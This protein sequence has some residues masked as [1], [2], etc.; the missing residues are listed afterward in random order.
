M[1]DPLDVHQLLSSSEIRNLAVFE[2]GRGEEFQ[3]GKS[4]GDKRGGHRESPA[5]RKVPEPGSYSSDR[6]ASMQYSLPSVSIPIS[7]L[8]PAEP[9]EN[10]MCPASWRI[11]RRIESASQKQAQREI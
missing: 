1:N 4:G 6:R 5:W 9:I 11:H 10:W 8:W 2:H 3:S 7:S